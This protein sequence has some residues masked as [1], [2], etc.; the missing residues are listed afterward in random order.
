MSADGALMAIS[1]QAVLGSE[2]DGTMRMVGQ[3]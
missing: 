3:I 2:T 1:L